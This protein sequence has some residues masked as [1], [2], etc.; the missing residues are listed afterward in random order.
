[1]LTLSPPQK[2]PKRLNLKSKVKKD[3]K[4]VKMNWK[5]SRSKRGLL[6]K[7][8]KN[9]PKRKPNCKRK[10]KK[11]KKSSTQPNTTKTDQ[12]WLMSLKNLLKHI[13][14]RINSRWSFPSVNSSPHMKQQSRKESFWKNKPQLPE[15]WQTSELRERI[16][17]FT[18]WKVMERSFKWCATSTT[19]KA[20][21]GLLKFTQNSEEV[22]SSGSS[23]NPEGPKEESCQL[24]QEKS[25]YFPHVFICCLK[26]MWD[27]RTNNPDTEK[28][29]W[30]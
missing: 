21:K 8:L 16:W 22:T 26:P 7:K 28:D 19:I 24:L 29:I 20:F 18:T 17:S 23:V 1:M 10:S 30:I 12:R 5:D 13:P 3:K 6:L 2:I 27:S 15:E 14:T 11:N 9:K 25:F 4:L